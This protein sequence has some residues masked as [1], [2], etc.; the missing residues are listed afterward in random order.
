MSELK[1]WSEVKSE[2]D[3][4]GIIVGNGASLS[5]WPHFKYESL[6]SIAKKE[7]YLDD[8]SDDIFSMLDTKDFERVLGTLR[9]TVSINAHLGLETSRLE[10][11]YRTVRKALGRA[12]SKIH[13]PW[14]E[15]LKKQ[16]QLIRSEI[17]KY[18]AVFS[19][20]YDLILYWA[21]LSENDFSG[22]TDFFWRKVT[23][24][25][26][27]E[28]FLAF[29]PGPPANADG[30][31]KVFYLHGGLHL[32]VLPNG[33]TAKYTRQTISGVSTQTLIDAFL[34]YA[35]GE[36]GK[37]IGDEPVPLL[38]T[39][40]D[41]MDKLQVISS[42]DYLWFAYDTLVNWRRPIVIFGHSLR[43]S[44]D[45]IVNAVASDKE[46]ALAISVF[47]GTEEEVERQIAEYRRRLVGHKK[48]R[49]FDATT[50]PLGD[51]S[52]RV[53]G[54]EIPGGPFAA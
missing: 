48:L 23:I 8:T 14:D 31:T 42:S 19:T 3:Y 34:R 28:T 33:K 13:I 46:R 47:P 36:G 39:G 35:M 15:R 10:D 16:L 43:E 54:D 7:R 25:E 9:V 38:V 41:A 51:P 17:L 45:H 1:T 24:R 4:R 40:G 53:R 49:F 5:V 18:D 6:Y 30:M 37:D 20:N 32:Y 52:L 27:E 2:C 11:M 21:L 26:G 12:V 29:D 44:D 50:H 22:F